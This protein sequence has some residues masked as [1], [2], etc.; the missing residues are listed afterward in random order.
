[1]DR[2]I[3]KILIAEDDEDLR[4]LLRLYLMRASY[5]VLS[6]GNGCDAYDLFEKNK[7]DLCI[8]D[9]M[10][11]GMNGFDL[12]RKIREK[13]K[14]PIIILSAKDREIDKVNGLE[15]GADDYLTKPFGEREL[16]ARVRAALRRYYDLNEAA[17]EQEAV[18]NAGKLSINTDTKKV[19]KDGEEIILTAMEYKILVLLMKNQGH[20]FTK[21]QVYENINGAYFEADA[22]TLMV[23]ISKIRE[24][25]ED[26]PKNPVYLKTVRGLGYKFE[27]INL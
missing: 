1:M 7:V 17:S 25:I 24:K 9:I 21:T 6:S 2:K 13:S 15:L 14:L 8:F 3:Y 22:N 4:E 11:P 23:H 26:D 5:S 19:I 16:L 10:M 27:K 18:I 12:T 20:V